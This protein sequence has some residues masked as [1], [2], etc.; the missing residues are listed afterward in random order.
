M[1]VLSKEPE[2]MDLPSGENDTEYTEFL[3]PSN[4]AMNM[5]V[6]TSQ[7]RTIRSKDPYYHQDNPAEWARTAAI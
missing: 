7:M 1:S 2:T 5:P 4:L 3:C 6:L